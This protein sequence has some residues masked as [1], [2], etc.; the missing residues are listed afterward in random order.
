MGWSVRKA[1]FRPNKAFPTNPKW[2]WAGS[3][4]GGG[5]LGSAHLG[6]A[7]CP[8]QPAARVLG[9]GMAGSSPLSLYKEP[10]APSLIHPLAFGCLSPPPLSLSIYL[11]SPE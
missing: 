4:K 2:E 3:I 9:R 1:S 7:P 11:S 6:G 10:P 8:L 5:R